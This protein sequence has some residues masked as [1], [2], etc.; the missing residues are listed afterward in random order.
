MIH[1]YPFMFGEKVC[2]LKGQTPAQ[3]GHNETQEGE[4]TLHRCETFAKTYLKGHQ[5]RLHNREFWGKETVSLQQ[6]FPDSCGSYNN[7]SRWRLDSDAVF[8]SYIAGKAWRGPV[9][10]SAQSERDAFWWLV[11]ILI[12]CL[13]ES[14]AFSLLNTT[15]RDYK[16]KC[17]QNRC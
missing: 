4:P 12:K 1:W 2:I 15:W 7:E 8:Q 16:L 17:G 5:S 13:I 11:H 9:T 6:Q 14:L 10:S 3:P